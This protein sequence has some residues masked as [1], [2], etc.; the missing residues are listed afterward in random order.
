MKLTL[1]NYS[2]A[3]YR[4]SQKMN[5]ETGLSVGLFDEVVSYSPKDI[6]SDFRSANDKILRQERGNGYWLWKPYFIWKTLEKAEKGDFVFYC[7]SG[8]HF[9]KPVSPL[10]EISI[11][12]QQ[13]IVFFE[14]PFQERV[15]TKRDAFILMGCDA[16]EY[17]DSN[18]RLGSYHLWKKSSFTMNFICEFLRYAQDERI[19]TDIENQCGLPDSHEFK[20]HRHDQ[21]I[22]S[23]LTKK[24]DLLAHRDPSQYGNKYMNKFPRSTYGQLINLTRMHNFSMKHK[25]LIF[26]RKFGFND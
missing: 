12:N 11:G 24:Y 4:K 16:S 22:F 26:K 1:V 3:L 7:D 20:N 17:A 6:D 14:L 15:Y 18:Q 8:A 2:D 10:V 19:L 9:I 13:D 23:L 25:F 5:S 21:S